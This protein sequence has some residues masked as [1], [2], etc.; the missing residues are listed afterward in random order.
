MYTILICDDDRDIV[1]ALDI[2]LT[3]EGYQTI[4]AYNGREAIRAAETH[5]IHLILMDVM[6]PELDGISQAAGG[7]QRAHHPA[8]R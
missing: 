4:K 5:E 7:E 8:H 1:S 6:M 3:S 2:Y